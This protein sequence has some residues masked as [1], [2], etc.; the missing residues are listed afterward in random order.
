M[1]RILPLQLGFLHY[2][3]DNPVS[4]EIFPISGLYN[5]RVND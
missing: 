3:V 5:C 1:A 4:C 2:C